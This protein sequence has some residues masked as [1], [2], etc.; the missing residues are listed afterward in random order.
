MC[1]SESSVGIVQCLENKELV[2][3]TPVALMKTY[4]NKSEIE[5]MLLAGIENKCLNKR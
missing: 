3:D 2:I 5:G 4:K 1:S